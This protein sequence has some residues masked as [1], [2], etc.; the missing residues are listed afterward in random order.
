MSVLEWL[1]RKQ[2]P[3]LVAINTMLGDIVQLD[4]HYV[5]PVNM[6][7]TLSVVTFSS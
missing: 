6:Q 4:T 3:I 7:Q 5:S 1:M 2:L